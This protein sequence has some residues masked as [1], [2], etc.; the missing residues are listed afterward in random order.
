MGDFYSLPKYNIKKRISNPLCWS[1]STE[2]R[3]KEFFLL[4]DLRGVKESIA[5]EMRIEKEK[6]SLI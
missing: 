4:I 1:W 3:L 5:G 6:G 2:P